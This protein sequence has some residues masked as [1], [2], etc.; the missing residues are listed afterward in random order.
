MPL[1]SQMFRSQAIYGDTNTWGA[2]I[3]GRQGGQWAQRPV[4]AAM[5]HA[6]PR[7]RPPSP[8]SASTDADLADLHRRGVITDAEL[9]TLSARLR[10]G[11]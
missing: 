1:L 7:P 6:A 2:Q 11:A 9:A 10:Q 8:Q 4:N 3:A 5:P